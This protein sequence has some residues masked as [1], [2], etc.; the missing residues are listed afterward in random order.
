MV[1]FFLLLQILFC[2][3]NCTIKKK[4]NMQY[5]KKKHV[6]ILIDKI[7]IVC[8]LNGCDYFLLG[9][10]CRDKPSDD[11]QCA[12]LSG[13]ADRT[14]RDWLNPKLTVVRQRT[15][16]ESTDRPRIKYR[17]LVPRRS[18]F[19]QSSGLPLIIRIRQQATEWMCSKPPKLFNPQTVIFILWLYFIIWK[20]ST[21][22]F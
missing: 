10:Y 9:V 7:L 4:V 12:A 3:S 18:T 2:Y 22:I 8:F 14:W 20:Q 19:R 21:N 15:V 5:I 17:A 16:S 6:N 11:E 1:F 13:S